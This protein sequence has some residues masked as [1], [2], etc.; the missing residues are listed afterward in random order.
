MDHVSFVKRIHELGGKLELTDWPDYNVEAPH[1]F[2]WNGDLHCAVVGYTNV[3]R[4]EF[5][6]RFP[7][8]PVVCTDPDCNYCR[9]PLGD[10]PKYM[11]EDIQL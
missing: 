1:G 7:D 3:D 11:I 2:T 8:T 9:D 4:A 5:F 6:E 10:D